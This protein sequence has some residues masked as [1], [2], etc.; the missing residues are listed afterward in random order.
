MKKHWVKYIDKEGDYVEKGVQKKYFFQYN[1]NIHV[2]MYI[3]IIDKSIT[4]VSN[5]E[6]F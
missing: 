5:R 2:S 1:I 4:F 6:N 3:L